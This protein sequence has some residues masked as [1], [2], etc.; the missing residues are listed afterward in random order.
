M[1]TQ[2]NLGRGIMITFKMDPSVAYVDATIYICFVNG[3]VLD[4]CMGLD[5]LAIG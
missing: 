2:P 5:Y 1:I 3:A 4:H